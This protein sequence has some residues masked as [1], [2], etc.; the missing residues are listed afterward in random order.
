MLSQS[1]CQ[2]PQ[3]V[4]EIRRQELDHETFRNICNF[5]PWISLKDVK[6]LSLEF[7]YE[8]ASL[9]LNNAAIVQLLRHMTGLESLRISFGE[10]NEEWPVHFSITTLFVNPLQWSCLRHLSLQSM[11]TYTS[12]LQ[13]LLPRHS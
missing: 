11:V 10:F 13:A 4:R 2:Y 7:W 12:R 3:R 9:P 6:L 8:H 5:V 1:K